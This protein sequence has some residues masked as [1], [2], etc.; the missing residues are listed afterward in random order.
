VRPLEL[1]AEDI[2]R[3]LG[4]L[5]DAGIRVEERE[6]QHSRLIGFSQDVPGDH[7]DGVLNRQD[8]SP[9]CLGRPDAVMSLQIEYHLR[10]VIGEQ[11][12]IREQPVVAPDDGAP[13]S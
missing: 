9:F 2:E 5:S 7:I 6:D 12:R 4:A 13:G 10:C 8:H 3:V 1:E 11:F